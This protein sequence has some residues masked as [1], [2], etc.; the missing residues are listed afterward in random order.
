MNKMTRRE[1]IGTAALGMAGAGLV[2][3]GIT[4]ASAQQPTTTRPFASNHVPKP[5]RFDPARL[6]GLSEKLI[7]SHWE[8]IIRDQCAG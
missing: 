3:S 2:G 4:P 1:A 5:L 8:K 6:T 7:T